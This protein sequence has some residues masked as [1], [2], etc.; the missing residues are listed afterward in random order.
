MRLYVEPM[1]TVLVDVAGDGRVKLENEDWSVPTLQERR[2]IIYA[3]NQEIA[4]LTELL[5][6][7]DAPAE[8]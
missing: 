1:D 7:L 4:A 8:P 2:A 6:I 3:A 5:E